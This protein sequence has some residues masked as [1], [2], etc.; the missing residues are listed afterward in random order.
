ML[1]SSKVLLKI[2]IRRRYRQADTDQTLFSFYFTYLWSC[3]FFQC[4]FG[5]TMLTTVGEHKPDTGS[6]QGL[7]L[8]YGA[9]WNYW[10]WVPE[11]HSARSWFCLAESLILLTCRLTD[12]TG[13]CFCLPVW[14][15]QSENRIVSTLPHSQHFINMYEVMLCI[16]S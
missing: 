8:A 11:S 14:T 5:P 10:W 13:R 7:G 15:S 3:S 1:R 16:I 9:A 12:A 2:A 6:F 4:A